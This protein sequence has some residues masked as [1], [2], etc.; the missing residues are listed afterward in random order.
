MD[1]LKVLPQIGLSRKLQLAPLALEDAL[2]GVQSQMAAQRILAKRSIAY[3]ARYLLV[4]A[5]VPLVQHLVEDAFGFGFG[6]A[7][8]Q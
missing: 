6:A 4:V 1:A 2:V 3:R 8:Q 5:I 7:L